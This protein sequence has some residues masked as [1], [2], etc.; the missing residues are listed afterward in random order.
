MKVLAT[1]LPEV[2]LLEPRVHEDARGWLLEAWQREGHAALGLPHAFAQDNLVESRP[3]VLRGLHLQHPQGQGKLVAALAGAVLDVAVDLRVGSPR[4]GRHA[5]VRLA[6]DER[7][8]LWIPPGFAHGYC[9]LGEVPALVSYKCSTAYRPEQELVLRWD[10]PD[11]AI[12]W[13]LAAPLLSA[14][15]AAAPLLRAFDPARLP[16]FAPGPSAP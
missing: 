3:G 1:A 10:D 13:P 5:A 2:L 16:R 4:F 11:L 7:R 12:A 15:D 6:A 14:K 9:V 8:Q